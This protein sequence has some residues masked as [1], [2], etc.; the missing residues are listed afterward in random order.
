VV[1]PAASLRMLKT[2]LP[3]GGQVVSY[4]LIRRNRRNALGLLLSHDFPND[5]VPNPKISGAS[6]VAAKQRKF[7]RV[8][9]LRP[10]PGYSMEA[11]QRSPRLL[12]GLMNLPMKPVTVR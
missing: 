12:C 1:K 4:G 3:K 11:Y 6:D 9:V 7:L 8:T 10:Y 5:S 2:P